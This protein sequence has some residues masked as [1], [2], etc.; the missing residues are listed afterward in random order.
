MHFTDKTGIKSLKLSQQSLVQEEGGEYSCKD[1][2]SSG[3]VI[4][5]RKWVLKG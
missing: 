5:E 3:G 1:L 4:V 2:I